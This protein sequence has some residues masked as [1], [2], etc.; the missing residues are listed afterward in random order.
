MASVPDE[1]L[2]EGKEHGGSPNNGGDSIKRL[3]PIARVILQGLY[4]R[5][6][7]LSKLKGLW[8][9][10]KKI[11]ENITDF[12]RANIGTNF[13]PSTISDFPNF[14][15]KIMSPPIA[16][17]ICVKELKFPVPTGIRISMMPFVMNNSDFKTC[18]LPDYLK[19]YWK[20]VISQCYI[21]K[22][23]VGKIGYLTIHE[24]FAPASNLR[25][26]PGIPTEIPGPVR[27]H[28]FRRCGFSIYEHMN[29]IRESQEKENGIYIASNASDS[30]KI[31]KCLIM[32]VSLIGEAGDVEHLREYL[33]NEFKT[34]KDNLYWL[35]E[36]T[37]YELL[38]LKDSTDRQFFG[39]VTGEVSI[40][41]EDH[42]TKNPLGVVPDPEKTKMVRWSHSD[43]NRV[44]PLDSSSS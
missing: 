23:R 28:K 20:N 33:P 13:Y 8:L 10:L 39:L 40:W 16:T 37:P 30:C 42:W 5:N 4:D 2:D 12:W 15:H 17:S 35:T 24:S 18:R 26:G 3:N 7:E 29:R 6:S 34:M 14:R 11:W 38:P 41:H 22:E 9:V 25:R 19:D 43:E 27:I 21:R 1:T 31:Y 32:D 44:V 36:R